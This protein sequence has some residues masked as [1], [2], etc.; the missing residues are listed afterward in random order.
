MILSAGIVS[1][2]SS[3]FPAYGT[4]IS[5]SSIT[6]TK[7]D[8]LG[9]AWSI[10]GTRSVYANG[11]GG[12]YTTDTWNPDPSGFYY[13]YSESS[14]E[15]ISWDLSMY[16]QG[17]GSGSFK[18]YYTYHYI[19]ADGMGGQINSDGI[20]STY[21]DMNGATIT[22][23]NGYDLNGNYCYYSV[24]AGYENGMRAAIYYIN[25]L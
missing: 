22:S 4:F 7:T 19:Q 17:G 6:S 3:S 14:Q 8:V 11:S 18:V 23:G 21:V 13:E 25:I 15:F 5:S 16:I 24:T 2:A 9:T 20:G 12:T 10:D 1:I